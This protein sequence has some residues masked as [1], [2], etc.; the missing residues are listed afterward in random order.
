MKYENL[1]N[2]E[3]VVLAK[4]GDL[5]VVN[6]LIARFESVIEFKASRFSSHHW[7]R[8]ELVQR[9]RIAVAKAVKKFDL[10]HESKSKFATYLNTCLENEFKTAISKINKKCSENIN[11][12]IFDLIN[13]DKNE[14]MSDERFNPEEIAINNEAE[15]ELKTVSL[16]ILSNIEQ[17]VYNL[18]N[19]GYK[20]GDISSELK[21]NKK[22]VENALTR[23]KQKFAKK[24]KVKDNY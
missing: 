23:I 7:I 11:S 16:E 14:F 6:V 5:S 15:Q 17:E 8:D 9:G 20:N 12:D 13:D 1:S 2:E 22:S 24:L 19:L 10:S 4:E 3:L 21:I 18:K